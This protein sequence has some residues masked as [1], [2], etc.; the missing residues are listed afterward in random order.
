MGRE[1]NSNF[2]IHRI[3]TKFRN[4]WLINILKNEFEF[5]ELK[6]E[7]ND[8]ISNRFK[9]FLFYFLFIIL[10]KLKFFR[11]CLMFDI[12]LQI[13]FFSPETFWKKIIEGSETFKLDLPSKGDSPFLFL[14]GVFPIC[15][16]KYNMLFLNL[17]TTLNYT[18]YF[19][20]TFAQF[21]S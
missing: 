11:S 14:Y 19:I 2:K 5:F 1:K 3:R 21:K 7:Q 8:N 20:T 18:R 16:P 17:P 6:S 12:L 10:H 4:R 13:F 9:V 15:I